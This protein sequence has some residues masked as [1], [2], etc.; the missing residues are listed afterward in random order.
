MIPI[1]TLVPGRTELV[2]WTDKKGRF[3]WLRAITFV[4]LLSP[5]AWLLFHW[6]TD[7]L[8]PRRVNAAIHST[9]YYAVWLLVA[10]LAI[11]PLKALSSVPGVVVV[12]RMVGN[13]AL[14]Y[15]LLH[16]GLYCMDQNW[17]WFTIGM[18]IVQRFYLT[19]GFVAL[20]GL[21][22][23]GFTSTDG[24]ARYLGK[25]WKRLH[26]V[27]YALMVLALF[28]YVLQSKLDV[29]RAM[30]A[31]GVFG[32]LMLWRALPAG[33]DREWPV[34]LAIS[35]GA[36]GLTLL[37][38]CLWYRF[39]TNADPIR[40]LWGEL[41][42]TFGWGSAAGV[43]VLGLCVTIATWLR[44]LALTRVGEAEW[45]TVLV[46]VVG[47]LACYPG[48]LFLGYALDDV[49][50][51]GWQHYVMDASWIGFIAVFGM[52][53]W[54]MRD[55]WQRHAADAVWLACLTERLVV[56]GGAARGLIGVA[57][58][59]VVVLGLRFGRRW[60]LAP[61]RAEPSS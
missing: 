20:L 46:Y 12:R 47:A 43:L 26:K 5:G 7:S 40:V 3:H 52:M 34:L 41:D 19:I 16:L 35:A 22:V 56:T 27:V 23:L 15:A 2:P 6:A 59:A 57:A 24:W 9:G 13:A 25:G 45:F 30:M 1:S 49:L 33:R 36:T 14:L 58:G 61:G 21:M 11:T 38:E 17:R 31:V 48:A 10:S 44:Q 51:D 32:W 55:G 4:L 39:G 53:R 29:S 8:G 50:P 42:V 18:E 37:A 54:A 60:W 28:H